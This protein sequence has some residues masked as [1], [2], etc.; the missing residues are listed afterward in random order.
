MNIKK[1][2]QLPLK[3]PMFLFSTALLALACVAMASSSDNARPL[4]HFTPQNGWMNDP[5]GPWYDAKD[6][7]W[8]LYFQYTPNDT[9]GLLDLHWGHA[10]SRDLSTWEDHGSII[11]PDEPGQ[12]IFSGSVVVDQNNTSGFFNDSVDPLQRAVAIYTLHSAEAQVQEVAYSTDGGYTFYKYENNP[13]LEV[14]STQFRDPKVF[15]HEPSNHWV[16]VVSK[17]QEF[18]IQI[19]GSNDLKNWVFHLDFAAGLYGFQYECPGLIEVPVE[20]TDKK[21]W[22]MFLAINPG[23][24]L[25]GSANQYFIGEFDGYKFVPDDTQTRIHDYGK[26]YYAFQTFSDTD[27][28]DGVL[29]V[30]W[31]SNWQYARRV[32]TDPWRGSTGVVRNH[33]LAKVPANP[34]SELL[35]LIQTPVIGSSIKSER[36][37]ETKNHTLNTDSPISVTPNKTGVFDIELT[38]TVSAEENQKKRINLSILSNV[39]DGKQEDIKLGYDANVEAFYVDRSI[40]N[41]FNKDPYF[42]DK[43]SAIAEPLETDEDLKTFRLRAIIDK[44]IVEVFLNDGV[45]AITNTFFMSEGLLPESLELSASS[46]DIY[47]VDLTVDELVPRE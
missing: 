14:N 41:E 42:T 15:W 16:M 43:I 30:S 38:F 31:A 22:V 47:T 45:S 34:Q 24:P 13:V 21:K 3:Y 6:D 39:Q 46:D 20:G 26:D 23:M 7:I 1:S 25:G 17:S 18:K 37:F 2:F 36:I 19:Y 28:K 9:T 44:N 29:G 10:S 40:D 33:T 11:A 5:N 27:E 8:H 4:I 32:P 35:T 12:G